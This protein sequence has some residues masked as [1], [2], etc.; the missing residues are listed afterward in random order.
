MIEPA[1]SPGQHCLDASKMAK[2]GRGGAAIEANSHAA[3]S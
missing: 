1:P 3:T 2:Q